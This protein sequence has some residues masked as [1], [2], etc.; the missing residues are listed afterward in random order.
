MAADDEIDLRVFLPQRPIVGNREVRD[1]D[2]DRCV[3]LLQQRQPRR[4][5]R[6]RDYG[7]AKAGHYR[8]YP[9]EFR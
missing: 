6:L 4:E 8:C 7:P 3:P 9:T 5:F 1:G 2:D